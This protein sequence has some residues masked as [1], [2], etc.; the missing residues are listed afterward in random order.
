MLRSIITSYLIIALI[1][2]GIG[3]KA[4]LSDLT[5]PK[6]DLSSWLVLLLA[7]LLW[8]IV[9]PVSCW[10]LATKNSRLQ[11]LKRCRG[12]EDRFLLQTKSPNR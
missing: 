7:P 12:N 8:L 5:T 3:L 1:V 10:E 6:T 11:R 2:F 9:V 4:F